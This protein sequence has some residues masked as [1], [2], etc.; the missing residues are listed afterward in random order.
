MAQVIFNSI[1]IPLLP[2]RSVTLRI[3][4]YVRKHNKNK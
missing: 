3:A 2:F 4:D 1:Y